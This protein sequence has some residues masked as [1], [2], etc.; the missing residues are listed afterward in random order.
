MT[1]VRR[2][3]CTAVLIAGTVAASLPVLAQDGPAKIALIQACYE[4]GLR[5]IAFFIVPSAM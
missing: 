5:R 3:S 4:A 1:T 2:L